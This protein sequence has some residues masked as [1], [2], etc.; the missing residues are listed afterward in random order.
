MPRAVC[1]DIYLRLVAF[2]ALLLFAQ[3]APAQDPTPSAELPDGVTIRA[4]VDP[5]RVTLGDPF[6]Y[7]VTIEG[8]ATEQQFDAPGFSQTG[9]LELL[10]GPSSR[11]EFTYDGQR[12]VMRRSWTYTLKATKTGVVN[13]PPTR[14]QI[15]GRW[16][17][18]NAIA[19]KIEDVPSLT[20]G[21]ADI[22]SGKSTSPDINRELEGN[23]FALAEFPEVVYRGQPVPLTIYIYRSPQLVPFN[24]WERVREASGSDFIIPETQEPVDSKMLDWQSVKFGDKEL[25]RA[26]LYTTWVVPTKSGDLRITPP[27]TRVYLSA[28]NRN[29]RRIEDLMFGPGLIPVE[30]ETRTMRVNVLEPP[31]KPA[32]A[33]LQVVGDLA[34]RVTVDRFDEKAGKATVPQRELMTVSVTIAGEGFLDLITAPTLP[35]LPGLVA[36]DKKTATKARIEGGRFMSQKT[37]EYIFQAL[38]PGDIT[39]PAMNFATFNPTTAQQ[40]S[41]SSQPVAITVTPAS[42]ETVLVGGAPDATAPDGSGRAKAKVLGGDVAYIDQSPLTTAAIAGGAFYTRP[43]FWLLQ[44]LP[45]LVSFGW[46]GWQLW[47]QADRRETPEARTRRIRR[48]VEEALAKARASLESASRDDFHALVSS[49]LLGYVATRLRASVMGLT[50][51]E[52]TSRLREQGVD[53]AALNRLAGLLNRCNSIRY[54]PAPDTPEARRQLLTEAGEVLASLEKETVA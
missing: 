7:T 13:I 49:S 37:F 22:I 11:N 4:E 33:V 5:V 51:E 20:G 29:S 10:S 27:Y 52:A 2:A 39:L 23:Y 36:V 26:P 48:E 34:T 32:D 6:R 21:L 44:L 28:Q 47:K 30:L 12:S 18:T 42:G 16:Y 40:S 38:Q 15:A 14:L 43:W 3:S 50:V 25:V 45:I 31:A 54:S 9:A 1:I 35:D 24:R 19:L 8:N 41:V 17:E 53:E 46:G